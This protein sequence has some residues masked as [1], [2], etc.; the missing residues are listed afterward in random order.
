MDNPIWG[1]GVGDDGADGFGIYCN[2]T[3]SLCFAAYYYIRAIPCSVSR[4]WADPDVRRILEGQRWVGSSR[5]PH[6]HR[7]LHL[8]RR[9]VRYEGAL[10]GQ[11]STF[12]LS[13]TPRL[14]K[15]VAARVLAGVTGQMVNLTLISLLLRME[16]S[17]AQSKAGSAFALSDWAGVELHPGYSL[18]AVFPP[19]GLTPMQWLKA[20]RTQAA[21]QAGNFGYGPALGANIE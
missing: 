7:V 15:N 9:G 11:F 17:W 2:G 16:Q 13:P 14:V 21:R 10:V 5:H 8:R 12:W 4:R 6:R 1:K 3:L 18:P 20:Q 19:C